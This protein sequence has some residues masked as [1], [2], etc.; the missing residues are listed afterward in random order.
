MYIMIINKDQVLNL[1]ILINLYKPETKLLLLIN[2][3]NNQDFIHTL[4][5]K[6]NTFYTLIFYIITDSKLL[7]KYKLVLSDLSLVL[8]YKTLLYV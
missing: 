8:N 7:I 5:T 6:H 4:L 2:R 1:R 3:I